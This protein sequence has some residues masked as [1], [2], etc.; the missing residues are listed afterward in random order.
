MKQFIFE[1]D[2]K[3]YFSL[4]CYSMI[5]VLTWI[6][7]PLWLPLLLSL[8]YGLALHMMKKALPQWFELL[9]IKMLPS[10]RDGEHLK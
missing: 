6:I 8:Q 3:S 10:V 4:K 9:K 7:P 1:S 2:H 5:I